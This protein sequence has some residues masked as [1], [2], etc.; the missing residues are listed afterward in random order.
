MRKNSAECP[1]STRVFRRFLCKACGFNFVE[2][3]A[4]TNEKTDA[5][6]AM[7]VILYSLG[8]TS[9]NP[10]ARQSRAYLILKGGSNST[11]FPPARTKSGA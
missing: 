2:C 11:G 7:R 4:G 6:K 8:K 1:S 10:D 3:D 5:E 9:F